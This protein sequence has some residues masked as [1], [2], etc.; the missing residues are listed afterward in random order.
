M[1]TSLS[2]VETYG[3]V[4]I[5]ILVLIG[6][7]VAARSETP[8]LAAVAAAVPTGIPLALFIVSSKQ[9]KKLGSAALTS[10]SDACL[11]G[12]V[13]TVAFALAMRAVARRGGTWPWMALAGY[14]SWLATWWVTGILF[15]SGLAE[16]IEE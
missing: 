4:V 3:S 6:V 16:K 9:G 11:R 13:G 5:S 10:F 7:E 2:V 8:T 1:D 14:A 15:E 12:S